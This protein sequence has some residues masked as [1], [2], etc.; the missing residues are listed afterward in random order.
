MNLVHTRNWTLSNT[1]FSQTQPLTTVLSL[2]FVPRDFDMQKGS[3]C[4]MDAPPMTSKPP[5]SDARLVTLPR[6]TNLRK[7][8]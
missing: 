8:H 2:T 5:K 3:V 6:D 7:S 4:P 1:Q